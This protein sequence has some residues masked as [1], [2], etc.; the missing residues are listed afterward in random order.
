M[1][2]KASLFVVAGFS[3]VFLV[4]ANNFGTVSNRSI[5]NYAKYF[6]LTTTHN[7]AISGANIAANQIYLDPTWNTGYND[8]SYQG[9][10]LDV[11]VNVV[12]AYQNILEIVSV[13]TYDR[14]TDTVKVTLAPSKFSK[15]A[16]FSV[17]EGS[18]IWWTEND[19]VWGPFHT[20]D[21]MR[22]YHHPVFYGKATTRK[23]L[24]YYSSQWQDKP[25]FYGGFEQGVNLPIPDN[26]V[27]DIEPEAVSNGLYFTGHDTVYMNFDYDSLKYKY[28]YSDDYTTVYLPDA[29]PNGVVFANGS[30]VRLQGVVQGQYSVVSAAA[31]SEIEVT[32]GY[33]RHRRTEIQTISS[34]G[35]IYLDDDIVFSKDPR[36]DPTSTDL[37]GIIAEDNVWITDNAANNNNINIDASIFCENGGFGA[38][39]YDRRPDSGNINLLGGIIQDTR[40]AVGTFSSYGV[41]SGFSKR[42]MYDNRLLVA[43]PPMFPG[44]GSFEIVAWYE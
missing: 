5:D 38:E 35:T 22:V 2:G 8:L 16:Y 21:Y 27:S 11:S 28:S 9:G 42:Y 13:G 44:T 18:S 32:V 26:S 17:N 3:L 15:F 33:G 39:N 43:S 37:F 29:S 34:G 36:T 19:T 31:T 20:Q 41:S 7:I 1:G 4:I 10:N 40:Q 23:N 30:T 24:I 25:Y 14:F 6:D 12:N